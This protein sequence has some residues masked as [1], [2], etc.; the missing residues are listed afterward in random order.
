MPKGLWADRLLT[1]RDLW[2]LLEMIPVARR[3]MP[4]LVLLGLV[5]SLAET[6]GI[7]LVILFLYA[8]LGQLDQ[9][10]GVARTFGD[11]ALWVIQTVGGP[12]Q[13]AA[14]I[15][16]LI[17]LRGIVAYAYNRI[18]SALSARISETAR[19]RIHR[20]YLHVAYE[21]FRRHEQAELMEILGNNS[22]GVATVNSALTR[23]I[24]N[25]C[26]IL[27]FGIFLFAMSW[28]ITL[29][30]ALCAMLVSFFLG[31]LSGP[32]TELGA[33]VKAEHQ[34]MSA[35][36][37]MTL[38]SMRAIR[39]YGREAVQHRA[40]LLSSAAAR[41]SLT[42]LE[43][44]SAAISPATEIGYLAI[45]CM[46]VAG[47]SVLNIEFHATLTIV[48]LLYRLQPHLQEFEANLLLLA[49]YAPQL[50]AVRRMVGPEDKTFPADGSRP[51]PA[52]YDAIRFQNVTFAYDGNAALDG[53]SFH[54][55]RGKVTALVGASGSGKT[56]IV[57]LLLRLYAPDSGQIC[58][59][60]VRLDEIRRSEW[61]AEL[62]VAGQDIDVFEG[63][64]R[65]NVMMARGD[66]DDAA[67]T[68]AYALSH[69]TDLLAGLEYGDVSWVGQQGL[70][71]SGG[72]R[73]RVG[74]ARA[75]LRD[76]RILILDEATSALDGELEARI[77]SELEERFKGR[78]ILIITH[79]L[80]TVRNVDHVIR[81]GEGKLV[82]EGPPAGLLDQRT[83]ISAA[84]AT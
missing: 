13:L 70:N 33:T 47:A 39:A 66:A 59:G 46:I 84:T 29:A 54:I 77:R 51:M 35:L 43:R 12:V 81:L 30:A 64:V 32:V 80:E 4:F 50:R 14:A 79:R 15:F 68:D 74:I 6:M 11:A 40:F 1:L 73:Q 61:L 67:L 45:L 83:A 58:L 36:M 53:V 42:R 75:V 62:A 31:R 56:T 7:S 52:G 8:A 22:W 28:K 41:E 38:Q 2:A 23:L 44:L 63:T 21:F 26:A 34:S 72:Q 37:L 27:V 5:A 25:V 24:I 78:T 55:P 60:D 16:A 69:L 9:P 18:S 82:G 76:P 48:A 3:R 10:E 17:I 19:N 71:L 49:Q 57:N 20:Q 65:D